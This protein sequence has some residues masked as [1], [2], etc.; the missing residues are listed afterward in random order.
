MEKSLITSKY[1]FGEPLHSLRGYKVI[2]SSLCLKIESL[3]AGCEL[4]REKA[5]LFYLSVLRKQHSQSLCS[6]S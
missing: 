6:I 3:W 1:N 5:L 4:F 2:S